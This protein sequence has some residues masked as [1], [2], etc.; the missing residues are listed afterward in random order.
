MSNIF[1]P[2]EEKSSKLKEKQCPDFKPLDDGTLSGDPKYC[3]YSFICRQIGMKSDYI[4]YSGP[5]LCI[6]EGIIQT[7]F[8]ENTFDYLC[9]GIYAKFDERHLD[10][11]VS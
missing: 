10:E 4:W 7:C 5:G 11:E 1:I 9:T 8:Y 3:Q 6:Q 2:D